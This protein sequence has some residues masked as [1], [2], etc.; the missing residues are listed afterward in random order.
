MIYIPFPSAVAALGIALRGNM[1]WF[2]C[3]NE[4][5]QQVPSLGR[6]SLGFA[7]DCLLA[8]LCIYF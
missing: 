3:H 8:D 6:T 2:L 7:R 4:L 5:R 1:L